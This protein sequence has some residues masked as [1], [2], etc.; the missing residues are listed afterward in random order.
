MP[1]VKLAPIDEA[2]P[3][4]AQYYHGVIT[5]FDDVSHIWTIDQKFQAKRATSLLLK[6][7]IGAEV[8]F[9]AGQNSYFILDVLEQHGTS[10]LLME[11]DKALHWCAPKISLTAWNDL[12]FSAL[13]QIKLMGQHYSLSVAGTLVQQAQNLIQQAEH[14]SISAKGLLRLNAKQQI[15]TAKEDL[16]LDGKRINMG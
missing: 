5:G 15:I 12:E 2:K 11:S 13:K 16:R 7:S 3:T 9:V 10:E 4:P 8:S 14:F 1:H 6:P